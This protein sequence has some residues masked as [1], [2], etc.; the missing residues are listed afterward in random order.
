MN[1]ISETRSQSKFFLPLYISL[2]NTIGKKRKEP[3]AAAVVG[4]YFKNHHVQ[5]FGTLCN[6]NKF[7]SREK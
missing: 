2:G 3:Q 1:S 7:K 6:F 4:K 5:N